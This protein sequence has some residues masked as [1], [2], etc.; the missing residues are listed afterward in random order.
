M[1]AV[2]AVG[3]G[4]TSPVAAPG[5][6]GKTVAQCAA[7]QADPP[8]LAVDPP[9]GVGFAC[10]TLGCDSQKHLTVSNRGGGTLRVSILRLTI[11]SSTDFSM[12]IG[13]ALTGPATDAGDNATDDIDLPTPDAPLELSG[14]ASLDVMVRYLPS[15]G[16]VDEGAL[17]FESSDGSKP[18]DAE[19][20]RTDVIPLNTR[21]LG[22]PIALLQTQTLDFGYVAVGA[23]GTLALRVTN[24]ST[25][26]VLGVGPVTVD[27]DT[28]AVFAP[29]SAADWETRYTN[30][31]DDA[32]F[33]VTFTPATPEAFLGGLTVATS[34]PQ[35]PFVH[36]N[37]RG[38]AIVEPRVAL[39][40]P[41]GGVLEMAQVRSGTTRTQSIRVVNLGGAALTL[42]PAVVA[43]A[44]RGLQVGAALAATLGPLQET[45]FDVT[46][47][48][49][50]GGAM[51]G[52][53]AVATNDAL[54]P[55]LSVAV[56]AFITE[57][58]LSLTPGAI[59]FGN[60]VLGWSAD[61]QQLFLQNTGVGELTI[62]N[63]DFEV[64][65][66]PD[67]HL[68]DV[69]G[70]PIKLTPGDAPLPISV[71][72]N[73]NGLGAQHAVLLLTSDSVTA[74]VTRF[75]VNAN[76]VTCDV[77]CPTANGVPDCSGG[78]CEVGS[79]QQGFHDA[80]QAASS[81]C[82]CREDVIGNIIDDISGACPGLGLGDL[83]DNDGPVQRSGTLHTLAD[84]DLYFYRAIDSSQFLNDSY[85]AKV[86]LI[87]APAGMQICANFVD[88]SN[89]CGGAP[90]NCNP[91]EVRGSGQSGIFGG[92]D[93]SE[94]V[95]VFVMWA[96]GASPQCGS[97]TVNFVAN[98]NL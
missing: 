40:D 72:M 52:A 18:Y 71:F 92:N 64:G 78:V 29:A 81:G 11:D 10:V 69:P 33:S 3:A 39:V 66:S 91:L 58:V 13:T 14:D 73:A 68:A 96:P 2:G 75:D 70:L 48:A 20:S 8:R 5:C 77:G 9:F 82:E 16:T 31:G 28:A 67:I 51:A 95:T 19:V 60:V 27:V 56:N 53:I 42:A 26:S 7:A 54:T 41:A 79:C 30:P 87:G 32:L 37:V 93:D 23:S 49:V 76:V 90:T 84:V 86:Q 46:L 50:G 65:S 44:E 1:F 25:D 4:C 45:T 35:Q 12:R 97:Y 36:I 83:S 24:G 15:D 61:A 80:D 63:I 17:S 59:D 89:G 88:D 55:S 38:T 62:T 6:K 85:G 74:A 21:S 22:A 47:N 43:G 57:P 94:S 98:A 34:D